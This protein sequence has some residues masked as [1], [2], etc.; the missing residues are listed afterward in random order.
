MEF[1]SGLVLE[2]ESNRESV[3]YLNGLAVVTAGLPS[4]HRFYKAGCFFVK[5][6]VTTANDFDVLDD[7]GLGDVE[8][9]HN[10]TGN[11]FFR[12]LCGI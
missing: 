1:K 9:N 2:L 4:G 3:G 6:G 10:S 7:T 11:T 5:S 8:L 12:C